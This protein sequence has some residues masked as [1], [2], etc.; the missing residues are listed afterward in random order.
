[1]AYRI[2]LTRSAVKELQKLSS[3]THDNI[4]KH[5]R[6]LENDPRMPGSEKL[7]GIDAYK[8][9]VGNYRVI[10]EIDDRRRSVRDVMVDDRKQV[11]KRLRRI[12]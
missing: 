2:D 7:A 8:L 5:L 6:L 11:Y 10:Y 9:R 1:M 4:I 3:K 12:K